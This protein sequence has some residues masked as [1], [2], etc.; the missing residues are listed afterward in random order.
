[1]CTL[2]VYKKEKLILMFLHPD[3][4]KF[5]SLCP[6]ELTLLICLAASSTMLLCKYYSPAI[7][8]VFQSQ[9][10]PRLLLANAVFQM[11]FLLLAKLDSSF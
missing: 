4:Q 2:N 5:S 7:L 1:M 10:C 6:H 8:A 3:F 9:E 11:V